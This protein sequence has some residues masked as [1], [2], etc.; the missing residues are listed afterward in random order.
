MSLFFVF[1]LKKVKYL[2]IFLQYSPSEKYAVVYLQ[3]IGSYILCLSALY[4]LVVNYSALLQFS[5]CIYMNTTVYIK[6]LS[7]LILSLP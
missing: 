4:P 7:I 5:G 3:L 2:Y 6:L 1:H